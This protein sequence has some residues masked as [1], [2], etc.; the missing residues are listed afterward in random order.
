MNEEQALP[1]FV[2]YSPRLGEIFISRSYLRH[3]IGAYHDA[4][5]LVTDQHRG[6]RLSAVHSQKQ[7]H[8]S[9]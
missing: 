1:K 4:A 6:A 8:G 2:N 9:R 3:P 7:F 5:A